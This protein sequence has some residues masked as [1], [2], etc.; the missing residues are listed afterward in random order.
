MDTAIQEIIN[1]QNAAAAENNKGKENEGGQG[2]PVTPEGQQVNTGEVKTEKQ[3]ETTTEK[4]LEAQP[5]GQTEKQPDET[6]EEQK[7]TFIDNLNKE[8]KQSFTNRE[9]ISNVFD[10]IGKYEEFKNSLK[11]LESDKK[12]F[13]E[14]KAAIEKE[15]D[16]MMK[17]S[18]PE[19]I[20]GSQ[21]KYRNY[22]VA[23]KYES[24]DKDVQAAMAIMNAD[25]KEMNSL[26]QVALV[27]MFNNKDSYNDAAAA[28]LISVDAEI[29]KEMSDDEL[30][31]IYKN[32][33]YPQK[34]KLNEMATDAMKTFKEVKET[35]VD[36]KDYWKNYEE[37]QEQ[38]KKEKHERE[39]SLKEAWKPE[40]GNIRQGVEKYVHEQE[41]EDGEKDT[42]EYSL[43]KETMDK[44]EDI[45]LDTVIKNDLEKTPENIEKLKTSLI[46]EYM[47]DNWIK[48]FSSSLRQL[49]SDMI[50]KHIQE[51]DNPTDFSSKA[52]AGG[53]KTPEEIAASQ[54]RA[55]GLT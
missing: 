42:F 32:L 4:Q 9:E 41:Y 52:N 26:E 11:T 18:R 35:Q 28:A 23:Q 47:A 21:E 25:P 46:K 14:Q 19:H 54:E 38:Y 6:G 29:D 3:T 5:Q 34:L 13:E 43:D 15:R 44:I 24:E 30:S 40:I 53:K 8:F 39:D 37:R 12:A 45:V 48:F 27:K 33:T 1:E 50:K 49:R 31:D 36:D 20:F 16:E 55:F 7:D 2:K 22:L 10:N 17:F 51:T